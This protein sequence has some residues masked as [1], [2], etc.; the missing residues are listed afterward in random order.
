MNK[1]E[2]IKFFFFCHSLG[3]ERDVPQDCLLRKLNPCTFERG[4]HCDAN[5][6]ELE[7]I[8]DQ[9]KTKLKLSTIH[10]QGYELYL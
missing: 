10:V 8:I 6:V 7:A 2:V 9:A 3:L 1:L 4:V 5:H